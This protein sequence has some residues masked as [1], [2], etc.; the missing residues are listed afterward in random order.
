M[1]RAAE[2]TKRYGFG[3]TAVTAL[4]DASFTIQ[5]GE[6]VAIMGPS[7]SGKSTLMNLIGLLDQPTSGSLSLGGTESSKLTPDQ[8]AELRNRHIGFVFQAYNLLARATALENVELPLVYAGA[9]RSER[10][11]KAE[12]ALAAVGL[13]HRAAHSPAELSGGEQQRVAVARALVNDPALI[14]ADEP[15]GALDSHRGLEILALFQTLHR[16]GR[17][18]V[19]VTHDETV[20]SCAARLLRLQDGSLVEDRTIGDRLDP[21]VMIKQRQMATGR[22]QV[23]TGSS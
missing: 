22:D 12:A 15:T 23:A 16:G 8:L 19:V 13:A 7:G 2:L 5:P 4:R 11:P 17:A 14:L 20:A 1:L 10:R 3:P 18:I 21:A 6:F 9:R